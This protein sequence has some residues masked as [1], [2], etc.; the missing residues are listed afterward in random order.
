MKLLVICEECRIAIVTSIKGNNIDTFIRKKC[1]MCHTDL[2][3]I[4]NSYN[5]ASIEHVEGWSLIEQTIR[6]EKKH[7][8][9]SNPNIK[10]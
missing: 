8:K 7:V 4:D 6:E 3:I 5:I 10:E 1:K 9:D 2:L